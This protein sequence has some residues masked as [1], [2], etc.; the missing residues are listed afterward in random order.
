[1]LRIYFRNRAGSRAFGQFYA[2]IARQIYSTISWRSYANLQ[3][4]HSA[5]EISHTALVG[6]N[7]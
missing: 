3:N 5:G 4:R 7:W 6:G 2:V 1:M